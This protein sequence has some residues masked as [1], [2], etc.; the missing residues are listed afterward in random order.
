MAR[1]R[2]EPERA[3]A[4]LDY[5]VAAVTPGLSAAAGR[6]LVESGAVRVDGRPGKKGDRLS[7]GQTVEIDD[8][9]G[10]RESPEGRRVRPNPAA[11]LSV[12]RV[13]P[14][15]VAVDKQAGVPSH[16]QVAD[17]TDTM[18]NAIVARFPECAGASSDP[19]E[20]GLCHRLDTATSGVLIAARNPEAWAALRAALSGG[21]CEKTY[22]AEVVG[23][24][25]ASGESTAAIGRSGRRGSQVVV[26]GGRNPLPAYTRWELVEAREGT[27]LV[28]VHLAKGRTHQVR[29]H[30]AAAGHPIV[31]DEVY[32]A[33]GGPLRLHAASVRFAHPETGKAILIEAPAPAWAK[34]RA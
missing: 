8:A 3:G 17:E 28:R 4:R 6:R 23:T 5:F 21:A 10:A 29:A 16:P 22:L 7:A 11:P 34:I 27:A 26:D 13:D 32:G 30:L 2:V 14:A 9:L 18:A 20:G 1:F 24:P 12:L 19:R 31:G 25:A 33:G 15:F